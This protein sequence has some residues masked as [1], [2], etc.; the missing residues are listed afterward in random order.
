MGVIGWIL[1]GLGAGAIARAFHRGTQV[2]GGGVGTLA[3]G[4]VGALLGGLLASV[5]GAGS[6]GSF[7]SLGTWLIAIA[8]AFLALALHSA[9][10]DVRRR[11]RSA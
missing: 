4:I 2:P 11:P 9:F 8:G 6:I 10:A 5:L 3:F 7:F 1:L